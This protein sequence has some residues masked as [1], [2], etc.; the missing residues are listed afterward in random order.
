[1]PGQVMTKSGYY[2]TVEETRTMVQKLDLGELDSRENKSLKRLVKLHERE[3]ELLLKEIEL[4]KRFGGLYARE[5]KIT[6]GLLEKSEKRR[7]GGR[8]FFQKLFRGIGQVVVV[9]AAIDAIR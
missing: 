7:S 1:M 5:A 9:S 2:F 8:G 3:E 4:E 6:A